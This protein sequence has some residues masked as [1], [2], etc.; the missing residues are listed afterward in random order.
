MPAITIAIATHKGGTGKTVTAMA[1]SAALARHGKKTLLVDLD[2][3]GHCTLGLG[4]DVASDEP[5]LR[6]I[7]TEPPVPAA[8]LIRPT[9][10]EALTILPSN[11]R[12]ERAAQFIYM[13][14]K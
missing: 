10:L 12:L 13:R 11:I 9:H 5:T 1:L 14:P 8:R 7:F 4:V 2:P 6:D 3:Q